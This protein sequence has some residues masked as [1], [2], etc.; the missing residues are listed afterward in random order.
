[1]IDIHCH[2]LPDTD[3]GA[4]HLEESKA[5][6]LKALEEGVTTI[7]ATPHHYNGTY[8][9]PKF[10]IFQKTKKLNDAFKAENIPLTVLPG[11]ETRIHGDLIK[12]LELGE[13]LTLADGGLYLFVELPS[14]HVPRYTPKMLY[15]IQQQGVIPIIVHPER[16]KELIEQPGMLYELVKNGAATQVTASSITGDFGKKVKTFSMQLIEHEL[17]HFIASD[18]HGT[19]KRPSRM[20]GAFE[21]VERKFGVDASYFFSENAEFLVKGQYI[22]MNEPQRIKKKKVFGLF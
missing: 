16:N 5:M 22:A 1:M 15:D 20:K 18:A 12:G 3:D 8:L 17:T 4:A 6:A 19:K 21:E 13:I 11:Q 2:I 7:I 14:D 10:D 9:N